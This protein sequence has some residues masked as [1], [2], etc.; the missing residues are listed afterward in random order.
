METKE[1]S[2]EKSKERFLL[3]IED[4]HQHA[5][6]KLSK[7]VY[8]FY[9]TGASTRIE[10]IADEYHKQ[11]KENSPQSSSQLW[12]QLYIFKNRIYSQKLIERAE[13]SSYKALII[14]VDSPQFGN[15]ESDFRN[16]FLLPDGI[17][18][19]NLI[20]ENNHFIKNIHQLSIDSSLSWNDI[21]KRNRYFQ[22]NRFR[23]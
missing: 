14:T 22:S 19:E 12:Y 3:N 13:A 2:Y 18:S 6:E 1:K 23:C 4:Y 9:S 11:I 15:R 21:Q 10:I 5:K 16:Q 20:D 17:Q 8:D 7:M